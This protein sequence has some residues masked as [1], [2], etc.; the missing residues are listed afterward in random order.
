MAR[1]RFSPRSVVQPLS[2]SWECA[3]TEA[4]AV[5][6]PD[7]L[8]DLYWLP[9][10]VP[11][12]F[13]AALLAAG[14]WDGEA[15]L[16]LDQHDI[17][18][19][20]HF[21]GGADE[22]LDFEGLATIAEVWLNG[23]L[24]FTSENMF[25]PHR[26]VVRT[27]EENHLHICFR[28]LSRWLAGQR[29]RA[30]W[31]PRLVSPSS[32][33]FA[34]TTLLGR[35]PGWC[36]TV[37]P[38]GPWR[39]ISRERRDGRIGIEAVD[40]TT[41]VLDSAGRVV[42][43][44]VVDLPPDVEAVVQCDGH[45]TSL[46]RTGPNV[47]QAVLTIPDVVLWWPH[48]H[49]KPTLHALTLHAGD[50][51]CDLGP[52][53]FRHIDAQR[54]DD[55]RG[56]SPVVN[57]TPVFCRGAC[58]T[59]PDIIALPGDA[60]AY[61][62]WLT[63]MRDAGMNMVRV[64]GT[65][66][67]EADDFYA[68]CDELGL[69]VWQDAML[70]NF[71][72]PA[73]ESFRASLAAEL[74]HFLQRTQANPSLAVF[75]GGSEVL[76]QAAMLGLP[77]EKI[78]A[79]L[80]TAFIPDI[81][82][83]HRPDVLYVP[84]S[85]SG[86]EWP[87][88]PNAGVTHYYGVGAYLRPLDD[89][90]RSGVRFA[91]ECLALANV[92]DAH[93]IEAL[94]VATTTDPRWKRAVPRDPG[95]GWDFDDVRDQYLAS[96]FHIDPLLLR[97]TDFSRYLELSRA[98]SCLLAEYVFG[99]WRRAGSGCGGGLVWQLQDLTP[100][101]GWG[102]I[103]S[104]GHKKPIWHALR[105]AFRFRQVFLSDEG[106]NGL[107]VHVLNETAAPMHAVLRLVCLKAGGQL[108]REAERRVTLPPR[109]AACHAS[110]DLLPEFFDITYAYRFGP[111]AHDVTLASLHD[112]ED[113]SLIADAVHFPGGPHLPPR[114]L[115]LEARVEQSGDGWHLCVVA[116]DFAQFLHIDDPS[117]VAEDDW[118]HLLPG[119]KYRISLRPVAETHAVPAGEIRALNMDRVVR[120]AGKA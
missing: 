120:Y 1:I 70:A 117:F 115:G 107:H 35:M 83:R 65:M 57:G 25:L 66:V 82:Q 86:G 69:L 23:A 51:R 52:I 61:R 4:G 109:A 85:P 92:P 97:A 76:Q 94:G 64:G 27:R 50:M 63:A 22:I 73:T 58:W 116:R 43:R 28:S 36:P 46:E 16:E 54:G 99:E 93:T 105:R 55:A 44:A 2:E 88:Q 113:D 78:D 47:L 59:N 95:A 45:T 29:G 38:V 60:A 13:A 26:I 67:Y 15:P 91:S 9:A 108:V 103:D 39:P 118:L 37:H 10:P 114:D 75:C 20:T 110:A 112:A 98:V 84:N 12:T 19:R 77:G 24:L 96:L 14:E 8:R 87:F 41:A 62:P 81:V 119:R 49:G 34:R 11:G 100:G 104:R 89:A 106:L 18:Y 31:R 33:R 71:D 74:T 102:V 90:R 56:F 68:L 32:L 48:T 6:S 111:R 17:W 40:L 3:R 5:S 7:R 72:Y 42:I 80:Y 21:A 79:S 30:R 101:A 53:G